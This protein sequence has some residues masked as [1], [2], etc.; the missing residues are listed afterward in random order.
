[1]TGIIDWA[2]GRARMVVAFVIL[3][4][5]AGT[6][7]YVELPKE[8]EPDIEI[9]ALFI[10]V[11]FPGISAEDAEKLLIKPM[12]TELS[13][14]D[15]LDSMTATA[16]EGYAGVALEFEF[17]WNKTKIIADVRDRMNA[18]EAKFPDG[19]EK[20]T[21]TEINFSEFPI[22]IV[23]LSGPLP[24]RT[25]LQVAQDLQDRLEGLEPVLEVAL[26]GH[27]MA[28]T[29]PEL[30]ANLMVFFFRDWAELPQ[31][32]NLDRLVPDLGPLVER[33]TAAGANQYRFFRFDEAGGIKAA[34]VFVRMDEEL[35]QLPAEAIA[36]NQMVQVI[37]LW[38][39]RAFTDQSPLAR[40]P[41]G[42]LVLRPEIA[43]VIRAGYDPV[44]PVMA[45]DA[46]HALRLA[47][48]VGGVQ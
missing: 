9:P 19:A 36:L 37:L 30:G 10:S 27:R 23:N 18:A 21:I 32:P 40:T 6:L 5:V 2:A 44:L 16:R 25:L 3:S 46:S 15:G 14:L 45:Q 28:E 48:R 43:Q 20:Y 12:E 47:A 34:F 29:D 13:D 22:I 17:G 41:D 8:G 31:V 39:D 33:L 26:A 35:A 42:T 7:A 24:E 1:M 11:P 4:I 38:S